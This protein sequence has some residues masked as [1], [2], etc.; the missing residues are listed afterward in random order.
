MR[1]KIMF[2]KKENALVQMSDSTQA[3]LGNLL[4]MLSALLWSSVYPQTRVSMNTTPPAR[5][6][7]KIYFSQ[8]SVV[9]KSP[10]CSSFL[11]SPRLLFPNCLLPKKCKKFFQKS[12]FLQRNFT[13]IGKNSALPRKRAGTSQRAELRK[14]TSEFSCC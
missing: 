14:T 9:R 3:Q 12:P 1:V 8:V 7:P 13:N 4:H 5:F 11:S 2:N 10:V 6:C